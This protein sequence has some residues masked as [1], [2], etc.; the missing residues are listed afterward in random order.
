MNT[1]CCLLVSRIRNADCSMSSHVACCL[2]RYVDKRGLTLY[3]IFTKSL[4]LWLKS[5]QIRIND[6]T[7]RACHLSEAISLTLT[8]SLHTLRLKM[9]KLHIFHTNRLILFYYIISIISQLSIC[10]YIILSSLTFQYPISKKFPNKAF[11]RHMDTQI[12]NNYIYIII[13]NISTYNRFIGLIVSFIRYEYH[14]NII[15]I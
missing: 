3:R 13:Y 6:T 1:S 9:I 11:L 2:G 15:L 5:L 4:S 10:Y 8:G 7:T 14:T 12:I